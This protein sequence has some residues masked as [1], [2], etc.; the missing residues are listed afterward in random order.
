MTSGSGLNV[1]EIKMQLQKFEMVDY[2][3]LILM[4]LSCSVIGIYFGFIEK[5]H[6]NEKDE[7]DYLV[8]G[9][10]MKV[11][12]IFRFSCQKKQTQNLKIPDHSS[13]D[14]IGRIIHIRNISFRYTY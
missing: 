4:L 13:I 1:G 8:G 5:K 10:K 14:V 9:R 3:M 7:E 6:K 12:K 2:V 11:I